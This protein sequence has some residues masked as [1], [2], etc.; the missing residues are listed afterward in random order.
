MQLFLTIFG[1]G[2]LSV[3][4]MGICYSAMR[5][6]AN[7]PEIHIASSVFLLMGSLVIPIMYMPILVAAVVSLLIAI[8]LV[9]ALQKTVYFGVGW[10]GFPALIIILAHA[11]AFWRVWL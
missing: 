3:G 1:Y 9:S 11:P 2:L 8:S 10:Y 4:A 6:A 5:W 7:T